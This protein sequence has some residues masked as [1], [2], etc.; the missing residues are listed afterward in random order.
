M[1]SSSARISPTAKSACLS[2]ALFLVAAAA[3][4]QSTAAVTNSNAPHGIAVANIDKAVKPGDDFYHYANGGW[5]ARTEIPADR[6][7]IGVFS[8]LADRSSKNV[9]AIIEEAAK[10][11][12]P[13]GSNTRKIADLYN[14]YMDESA[15]EA[16]GM[17]PL[18]PP[19]AEIAA[20][21][22]Q[23][24]LAAALGKTLRAD[25]DL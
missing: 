17:K 5:I 9:G 8:A 19:L 14:A 2:A 25:V 1:N 3:H 11:S 7:G 20:I 22:N 10:S 24:D 16:L 21:R 12:A 13:A 6:P 15:I 18:P 23:H 4:S